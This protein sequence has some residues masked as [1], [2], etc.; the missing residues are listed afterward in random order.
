MT[1]WGGEVV[2]NTDSIY[3]FISMGGDPIAMV[4]KYSD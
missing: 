3:L 1:S 2:I 4:N